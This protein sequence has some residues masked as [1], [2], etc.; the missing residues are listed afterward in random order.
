MSRLPDLDPSTLTP[1]Q[2]RV[3]EAILAGPRGVIH[4]PFQAWLA[5]PDLADRAQ[6]LGQ[7]ARFDSVPAARAFGTRDPSH[8]ESMAVGVRMVGA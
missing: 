6:K 1:D 3:Y 2:R 4:G 5:S 7:Y 8:R